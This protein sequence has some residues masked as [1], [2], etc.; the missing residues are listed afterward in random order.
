MLDSSRWHEPLGESLSR[1]KIDTL[2]RP[3]IDTFELVIHLSKVKQL[4]FSNVSP[5]DRQV[6]VEQQVCNI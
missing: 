3:L 4:A 1:L 2:K 5:V 6:W